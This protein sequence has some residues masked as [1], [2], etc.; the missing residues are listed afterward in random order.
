MQALWSRFFPTQ[1][2]NWVDL[3][4][5]QMISNLWKIVSQ[6][7]DYRSFFQANPS[8]MEDDD[9]LRIVVVVGKAHLIGMTELWH[10]HCLNVEFKECECPFPD[11]AEFLEKFKEKLIQRVMRSDTDGTEY[12]QARDL[13][14]MTLVS[15]K[16]RA[17]ADALS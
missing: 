13:N 7:N 14:G 5:A 8:F 1:N 4:N 3:R 2:Y 6:V 17:K 11:D 15:A 16:L 9:E 12:K 10:R